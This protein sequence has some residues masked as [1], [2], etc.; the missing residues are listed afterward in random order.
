MTSCHPFYPQFS[1]ELAVISWCPLHTVIRTEQCGIRKYGFPH[2]TN[3]VHEHIT[4][5]CISM[6]SQV[7]LESQPSLMALGVEEEQRESLVLV[8]NLAVLINRLTLL[9]KSLTYL[10]VAKVIYRLFQPHWQNHAVHIWFSGTTDTSQ[11][12]SV[13]RCQ[14]AGPDLGPCFS[15]LWDERRPEDPSLHRNIHTEKN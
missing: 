5:T 14:Y 4:K 13:V 1:Y 3:K 15:R 12:S 6:D 2:Y 9:N 11:T 7:S 8:I 10:L